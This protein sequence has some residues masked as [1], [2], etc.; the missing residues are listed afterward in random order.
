[1]H[2]AATM[3]DDGN[4]NGKTTMDSN[5]SSSPF[6]DLRTVSKFNSVLEVGYKNRSLCGQAPNFR[7]PLSF[8]VCAV[9]VFSSHFFSAQSY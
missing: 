8:P 2:K 4:Q 9:S 5:L 7:R 3:D 6:R 1:M